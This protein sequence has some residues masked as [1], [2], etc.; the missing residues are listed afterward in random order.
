LKMAGTNLFRS[1]LESCHVWRSKRPLDGW[2]ER[3]FCLESLRTACCLG[4]VQE[5]KLN[6]S[7]ATVCPP[8]LYGPTAHEPASVKQLA[9]NSANIYRLYNG[10][11]TEVPETAFFALWCAWRCW[12]IRQGLWGSQYR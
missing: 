6:F 8:M 2:C 12:G 3:I 10:S 7:L 11:L 9:T 4:F 5:K 1:R